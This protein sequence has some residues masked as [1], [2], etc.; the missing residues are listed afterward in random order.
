MEHRLNTD[1]S[2][3]SWHIRASSVKVRGSACHNSVC[4]KMLRSK[5][6][7]SVQESAAN[8]EI[9]LSVAAARTKIAC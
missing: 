3:G 5:L 7:D 9:S 1:S 2:K 6:P 8:G 4:S